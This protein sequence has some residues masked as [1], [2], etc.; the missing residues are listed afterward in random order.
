MPYGDR[1]GPNGLG[2]MTGRGAGFCAGYNTPGYANPYGGR[3]GGRAGYGFG[4]GRG[5]GYGRGYGRGFRWNAPVYGAAP[6]YAPA[7]ISKDDEK[8]YLE[9][10]IDIIE[11]ELKAARDRLNE[12]SDKKEKK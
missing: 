8:K 10:E 3:F 5:A 1:T 11:K 9:N 7:P 12:I 2:P 4:R 6:M